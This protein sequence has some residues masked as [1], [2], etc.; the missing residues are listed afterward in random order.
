MKQDDSLFNRGFVTLTILFLFVSSATA[1]FFYLQQYLLL[2][3]VHPSWIGLIIGADSIASF[4]IQPLCAPYLH[5]GNS[6]RWMAVG[7][8]I[9]ALAL[10]AYILLKSTG[11]LFAIRITQGIGFVLFL[12][13]MMALIVAYIPQSKSGQGFGFLSLVRLVPYAIVPPIVSFLMGHSLSFPQ[14][15]LCFGLLLVLSLST[16]AFLAPSRQG[17]EQ[18]ETHTAKSVGIGAAAAGLK[19]RTMVSLLAINLLVYVCYAAAFFYIAG[20]AKEKGIARPDLFFTIA[21]IMMVVIRLAGSSIFDKLNK[22]TTSFWCL[23]VLAGSFALLI[24][25][26][27]ILFYILAA[28][29]GLAWGILLP[30][31]NAMVFDASLPHLRG[32]N[33]NLTLTAMQA[34]FFLGPLGGGLALTYSSYRALFF[35]CCPITILA[36]VAVLVGRPPKETT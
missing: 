21:T 7:I 35:M 27:G 13:A 15:L 14:V 10:G 9:L 5:A 18:P 23:L 8:I 16:F 11:L 2:L 26:H 20:F 6:R 19:D 4:V 22:Y 34:G 33:L 17:G 3:K 28:V 30:L 29:F 31:L 32:V 25:A 36:I 12:A 24:H 1:A